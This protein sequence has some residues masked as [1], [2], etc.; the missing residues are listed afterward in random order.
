MQAEAKGTVD[1][2]TMCVPVLLCISSSASLSQAFFLLIISE[3]ILISVEITRATGIL[4][5]AKH[6]AL[7]FLFF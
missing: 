6:F 3:I 2:R 5:V 7:A 1:I 4:Q